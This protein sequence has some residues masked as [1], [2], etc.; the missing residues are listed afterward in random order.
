MSTPADVPPTATAIAAAVRAGTLAPVDAVR[1]AL[2]RIAARDGAVG[3]FQRVRAEAAL[4]E[5]A[6]LA[7]RADLAALPL[8]G[9]PIAIKDNVAVTGEPMRGGTRASSERPS[10]HDHP[11]VARLRAAGAIVVGLT[12]VPE[13]CLWP[14]TD[15]PLG[16]A[17][18]PWDLARTPGGSSGG[19]AAAVAAGMVPIALGNDGLGSIRIPAA[20]C[21]LVGI[22]PGRG[23][24][25]ALIGADSWFGWAENGPLATTV[26]DAALMLDVLADAPIA[27]AP[28][29]AAPI[30]TASAGDRWRVALALR[31]PLPGTPVAP[32]WRAAAEHA[33]SVLGAAGH[34]VRAAQPPAPMARAPQVLLGWM[35]GAAHDLAAMAHDAGLD[36][37]S[38]DARV[39]PRTRRHAAAGRLA[40]RLGRVRPADHA[41][42]RALQLAFFRDVDLLVTPALAGAP[43]P[44]DGWARRGWLATLNAS[45]RFAPF[46]AAWNVAGFPAATVPMGLDGDGLPVAAQLVAAPGG[47]ARLVAAA[48]LLEAAVGWPR[49]AP[50]GRGG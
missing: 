23:V 34:A 48:R 4:A 5:A 46:A 45:T 35:A 31:P 25:P 14:F 26:D 9:V 38:A 12:R 7:T 49:M 42:W 18:N 24:V 10:T 28:I 11:V 20:C 32:A 17:R 27:T 13:L 19:S 39:E 29:A 47:E 6:A 30:A 36:A 22:K 43:L 44:A 33:A 8:A 16:T 50:M 21:G 15:G 37:A 1:A 3:A 2:D 41:A 40:E